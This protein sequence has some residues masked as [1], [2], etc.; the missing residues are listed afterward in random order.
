ME[1]KNNYIRPLLTDMYQLTM[2]YAYWKNNHHNDFA[3][4]DAFFRK[5]PFEGEYCILAGVEDLVK[6]LESFHF[7]NEEIDYLRAQM[8]YAE[9]EFFEWIRSLDCKA[10]K[11]YTMPEGTVVFPK[12]PLV[13]VE[14]PL[15]LAQLIETTLLNLLNFSSLIATNASRMARV[16]GTN[17]VMIEFGLRRAQGSDGAMTAS[18]CAYIGGFHKTSNVLAGYLYGIPISGTHAHA[19]V[20]SYIGPEDL[21]VRELDGIDLYELADSYRSEMGWETND[22][23]LAGFVSYA[24]AHPSNFLALVDTYDTLKSGVKNFI[25]VSLALAKL[26]HKAIGIRLDSGDLAYLSKQSRALFNS[27]QEKFGI[28]LSHLVIVASNDINEKVLQSLNDQK[29]QIDVFGVGTHLVTCQAQPALGMVYKLV[30][31]KGHARIK[32]SNDKEKINLPGRK[33]IYRLYSSSNIAL[34]D[35]VA[36]Q[37]E[38]APEAGHKILV[39]H[40][41]DEMKRMY[42]VPSRVEKML[43]LIWDGG[44][45]EPLLTIHQARARVQHQ[46]ET[47][48]EDVLRNLNPTPYKISVTVNLFN[49]IKQLL[50]SETP[51]PEFS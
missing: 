21:N 50:E 5:C 16:A 47:I 22:G 40:P 20:S 6:F 44:L 26:G 24:I 11:I 3:V 2:A 30:D 17:K 29:H 32:L 35:L 10:L 33:T 9:P 18:R 34:C 46:F 1:I 51:I 8:P 4:F 13:R 45:V 39:R 36:L 7:E 19:Y 27:A 38:P 37:D 15:A 31:I 41:F 43:N 42:V 48:R 14:G 28:D 25:C 23:E 49:H 12:M